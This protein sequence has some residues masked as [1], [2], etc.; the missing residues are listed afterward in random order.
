MPGLCGLHERGAAFPLPLLF[1]GFVAVEVDLGDELDLSLCAKA[2]LEGEL[3]DADADALRADLEV[4]LF[5]VL[6]E[7]RGELF[8][9]PERERISFRWRNQCVE[10]WFVQ[11]HRRDEVGDQV[12][13]G[14]FLVEF[15]QGIGDNPAYTRPRV[16]VHGGVQNLKNVRGEELLDVKAVLFIVALD[17]HVER[18]AYFID[19]AVGR[20]RVAA[21]AT[22]AFEAD[23]AARDADGGVVEVGLKGCWPTALS[24]HQKCPESAFGEHRV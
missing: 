24:R 22:L 17:A 16:L 13:D 9:E 20:V 8:I 4:E 5:P 1:A 6:E 19:V 2:R 7:E 15:E 14:V 10:Q 18:D 21:G 3:G 12:V 11:A 23:S